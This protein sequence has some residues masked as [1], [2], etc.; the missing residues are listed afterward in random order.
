MA[1]ERELDE[2]VAWYRSRPISRRA[3]VQRAL[4]LGLSVPAAAALLAACGSD[5]DDDTGQATGTTTAGGTLQGRVQI[6]VGF[7]TGNAP[8]QVPVQAALAQAFMTENPGVTIEF[9]RVPGGSGDAR[10]KLTTLIAGGEPPDL[11]M[12]AGLYGISL[13]VDQDVWLDLAPLA[14][15]DGLS[16]EVFLPETA[17]ATGV[18][19][20]YGSGSTHIV[21]LP[22]GVH[23][24]VLA[25]NVELFSQ[26][27]VP[28]PP[29]DWSDGSWTL[30]GPFLEAARALTV[31]GSGRNPG[32]AGFDA[33]AIE[34]FG[35]GH[36][37]REGV[38]YAFGGHLYDAASRTAQ[39]TLPG[40]IAGI[41]FAADLVNR[42]RVQPSPTDVAS[43]GA[44]ASQGD[45][46]QFA[47][48][49][50]KLAMID[51]CS[52]D[53]KSPY[54]TGVPFEWKAAAMPTGP[55]RRFAFLNLDV[56]ALVKAGRNHELAWQVLKYF[57][58]DPAAERRLAYESYGA[59][60]PLRANADAFVTGIK[61]DLPSVDP[62]VWLN[63]LP[64][65]SPENESWFPAFA[66]VND[67]VGKT[68][69][70]IIGGTAAAQAMPSLQ[71]AA[72]AKIDEWFRAN[73]LPS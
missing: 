52:C 19:N 65:A 70:Q 50:G 71:Q 45:E 44:G 61:A 54:G 27:G 38:F 36:F 29:T 73:T 25:Y 13:F 58:V 32:D 3:F 53:I 41:Q 26:A 43:L 6:L 60:P 11:V 20:Y 31:D 47:W 10:T 40:S 14:E 30:E 18:T 68:F 12:P 34:R 39:F 48:R 1:R 15:R 63:G 46:E 17:S 22:V 2:L 49:A 55:E 56:G 28:A 67:L 35:V 62:Q 57:A 23:D 7:G 42:H 51:M 8:A 72:Q 37:F 59:V 69:D 21:G 9:L 16:L 66:E 64:S 33:G 24:H 5:D 4:G